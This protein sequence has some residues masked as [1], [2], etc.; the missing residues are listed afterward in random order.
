MR[1]FYLFFILLLRIAVTASPPQYGSFHSLFMVER[2][3]RDSY[4]FAAH[5]AYSGTRRR[6]LRLV[7]WFRYVGGMTR[8]ER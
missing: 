5:V 4:A 3:L 6:L 7:W 8:I 2:R 1:T